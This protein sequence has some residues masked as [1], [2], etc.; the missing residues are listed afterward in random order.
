MTN[1]TPPVD[2][3]WELTATQI[4]PFLLN[5][6]ITVEQYAKSLLY[7]IET[8]DTQLKA[9][10][11]LDPNLIISQARHL[12]SL[13]HDKRGPLHGLPVAVKDIILTAD[14]PTQ[15]NSSLCQST[16][17]STVDASVVR[18]LR[19]SGALIFGKTTTTEF[20]ATTVGNHHQNLTCNAHATDRTPGG[21]SSGSAAAVADFHLPLA[22]GTQ[23]GGSVVRPASFNGCWGIKWTWGA[24]CHEGVGQYSVSCDT[25]G[26][27]ARCAEDLELVTRVLR[28]QD[29]S[30]SSS[31]SK[32]NEVNL[33][34]SRI[35][36]CKTHVWNDKADPSL[37]KAWE[38]AKSLVDVAGAKIDD[39]NLPE[40]FANFPKWHADI[41]AG[42]GRNAFVGAYLTDQKQLA[43]SLCE[44]VKNTK[45][46]SRKSQLEAYDGAARLRP[47]WDDLASNYDAVITPSVPGE[48]PLGLEWTGD[49][50]SR[51]L[52]SSRQANGILVLQRDVVITSSS[53]GKRAWAFGGERHACRIDGG[54]SAIY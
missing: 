20:A 25:L 40:D 4:L 28:V 30:L 44:V 3:L 47:V 52:S 1:S 24:V 51:H 38:K 36:F 29:E 10:V 9:W 7:R 34:G 53:D 46:V 54:W 5:N 42:E 14:M 19:A 33:K 37:Q 32:K 49:A 23:T 22:L 43:P 31:S 15:Y 48:A 21:S 13:P 39:L 16:Y 17:P 12:D 27:F 50:V 35:A 8:R 11:H 26:V 45:K 6:Q 41:A 2:T 18:A